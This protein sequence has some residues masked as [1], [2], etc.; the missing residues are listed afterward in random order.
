[1]RDNKWAIPVAINNKY[2]I[3]S[4]CSRVVRPR[5]QFK[6]FDKTCWVNT[7][8]ARPSLR[9]INVT[10][11][12]HYC[13]I[14]SA[15]YSLRSTTDRRLLPKHAV[16]SPSLS[17]FWGRGEMNG[18]HVVCSHFFFESYFESVAK[19]AGSLLASA[20]FTVLCQS[21]W[22]HTTELSGGGP[23]NHF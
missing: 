8:R 14:S 4:V 13:A 23:Y 10:L 9:D 5:V 7:V 15:F 19:E 18:E 3:V 20:D 16:F 1:M 21:P 12:W 17:L 22:W 2:S 6:S 11:M